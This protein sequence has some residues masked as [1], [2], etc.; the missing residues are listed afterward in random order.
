MPECIHK[1]TLQEFINPCPFFRKE[2][3]SFFITDRVVDINLPVR[4]IKIPAYQQIGFIFPEISQKTERIEKEVLFPV[5]REFV[6]DSGQVKREV[7]SL[8]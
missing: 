2:P 1:T 6:Y 8:V 7:Y 5:Y 4:Y 3:G